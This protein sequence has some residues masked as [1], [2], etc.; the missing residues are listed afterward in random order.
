MPKNKQQP[1]QVPQQQNVSVSVNL[2]T[3]PILF[4]DN[5]LITANENGIVLDVAQKLA[6]SNQTRIVSRVGMSR[7]HAKKFAAELSRLIAL[8]ESK[9]GS[10]S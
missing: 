1:M 7:T 3:T 9:P 6:S 2:D 8:T 5:I 10:G 4:A